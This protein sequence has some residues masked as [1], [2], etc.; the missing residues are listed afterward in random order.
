MPSHICMTQCIYQ[1]F[2]ST[3]DFDSLRHLKC[4]YIKQNVN[5]SWN[6]KYT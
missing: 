1:I 2:Y 4:F 6:D 3:Q 5:F